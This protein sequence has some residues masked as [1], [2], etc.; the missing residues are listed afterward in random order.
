MPRKPL[1]PL[2]PTFPVR[3]VIRPKLPVKFTLPRQPLFVGSYYRVNVS[4]S[5]NLAGL[6]FVV[7]EG[8][9][10]GL[11]SPS[12][13]KFFQPERPHIMLCVG[14]EPGTYRLQ[15]IKRSNGRVVGEGK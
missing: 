11:V 13:D 7:P 10:G 5:L 8:P 4:T 2:K 3:P 12:R 14:Y 9:A 6:D 1:D 15:A